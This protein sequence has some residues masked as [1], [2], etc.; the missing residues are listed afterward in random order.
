MQEVDFKLIKSLSLPEIWVEVMPYYTLDK[1]LG[2]GTY[3]T[4]VGAK[5]I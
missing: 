4:V 3:G 2:S 1:K 5:C